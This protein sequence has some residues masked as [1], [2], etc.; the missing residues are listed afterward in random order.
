VWGQDAWALNDKLKSVLGLRVEQWSAYNGLT[1][2]VYAGTVDTDTCKVATKLCAIDHAERDK[3]WIS[4]KAALGWQAGEDWVLK[5]SVGRAVRLPTVSELY[6]GGVNAQGI[7]INNN[8]NL[9]PERSVTSELSSE[10]NFAATALRTTLFYET[11]HDA[12][13][14]LLNTATNQSNIQN[15]DHVRTRGIETALN[16]Q[17]V[18][19]LK[20]VDL[21]ASLTYTDSKVVESAGFVKVPGDVVG[22]DQI[23]VP[24]WRA[25]LL[26]GWR[27]SDKLSTS[28]GARYGS[29]QFTNLD[30]SDPN[31]FAYTAS[32]KYATADWRLRYQFDKQWSAAVGVDNLFGYTYWNFHPYP[33]RSY[34]AELKFDL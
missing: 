30:N 4:P 3:T 6:Q 31:G 20:G 12:L 28:L 23:R 25:S 32:S 15:V 10:W 9:K 13:Y 5:A 17:D 11:T 16:T 19:G 26:A 1:Q 34:N 29:R 22:K 7:T 24:R 18:A 27:V 21:Q 8:P 14:S 2:S 33:Q